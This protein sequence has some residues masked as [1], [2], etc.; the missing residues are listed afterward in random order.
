MSADNS[1]AAGSSTRG[2]GP[3]PSAA[4]GQASGRRSVCC[5][6]EMDRLDP[7]DGGSDPTTEHQGWRCPCGAAGVLVVRGEEVLRRIGPAV[8]ATYGSGRQ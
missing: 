1:A 5:H 3:A 7:V 4:G 2:V 6:A 8:D